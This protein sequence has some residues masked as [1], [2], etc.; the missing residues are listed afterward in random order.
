MAICVLCGEEVSFLGQKVIHLCSTEQVLCPSC[1]K[2]YSRADKPEQSRLRDKIIASPHLKKR[3]QVQEFLRANRE[4]MQRRER[5]AIRAQERADFLREHMALKL[6][7][8]D[9]PMD[10]LGPG[11]YTQQSL[12][13]LTPSFPRR[14]DV[15]ECPV[16]GQVK[17][18]NQDFVPEE[19]K[20]EERSDG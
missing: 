19:L 10:Y 13:L 9:T 12:E 2:L 20:K 1:W 8:C 14:V 11:N 3:E 4:A 5:E 6:R 7:C 15:F 17:F 16:C 18:F